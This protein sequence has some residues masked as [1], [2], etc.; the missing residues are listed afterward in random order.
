MQD[1][2]VEYGDWEKFFALFHQRFLPEPVLRQKEEEFNKLLQGSKSA[3]EYHAEFSTLARYAPHLLQDEPRLARK[4]RSGL[5]FE[6]VRQMGGVTIDTVAQMVEVAQTVKI[7]INLERAAKPLV[8][9]KGK[10]KV[11]VGASRWKKRKTGGG[12]PVGT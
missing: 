4:F 8:D 3:W 11:P 1:Q 6:V 2:F 9:M 12:V 5:R 10:G 7:D